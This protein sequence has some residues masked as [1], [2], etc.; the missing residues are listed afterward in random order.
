MLNI[1]IVE[2]EPPI[3]RSLKNMIE[4]LNS[5]Y[6]VLFTARNGRDALC[7]LEDAHKKIDVLFTD[8]RMPVMDGLALMKEVSEK[9][10]SVSLVVLSGYQDFSYVKHALNCK[11]VD[12]LL[13]PISR[14]NLAELM[15]A[16]NTKI[17]QR[18][19]KEL[20][21]QI[22][23]LLEGTAPRNAQLVS[24]YSHYLVALICVGAYPSF[25]ADYRLPGRQLWETTDLSSMLAN[26]LLPNTQAFSFPGKTSAEKIVV[27]FFSDESPMSRQSIT[28][29][30]TWAVSLF[31]ALKETKFP[32]TVVVSDPLSDICQIE[33][34]ANQLRVGLSKKVIIGAS[35]MMTIKEAN[36]SIQA[37]RDFLADK[38]KAIKAALHSNKEDEFKALLQSLFQFF[39]VYKY[40][41]C[42]AEQVLNHL[43]LI[44]CCD[45]SFEKNLPDNLALDIN[46][47]ASNSLSY[48]EFY[49]NV[50]FVF[51]EYFHLPQSTDESIPRKLP[52]KLLADI[53]AYL[54][55]HYTEDITNAT[56][57]RKFNLVPSYLSKLFKTYTGATPSKYLLNLR[58]EHAKHMIEQDPRRLSKDIALN[59]G[60]TDPLYFSRIFKKETGYSPAEY[61]KLCE[62]QRK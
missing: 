46:E 20:E 60:F 44:C 24:G 53:E 57:S 47:A 3:A 42:L 8:I 59:V 1:M 34:I 28:D 12:Y 33:D 54:Q 38:E 62:Q 49:R 30:H 29:M 26:I 10:P 41:Q 37:R 6:S 36:I 23:S 52:S 14:Q 51:E 11:A 32:I 17:S 15:T 9:Y 56:L 19:S 13:K 25:S 43:I 39:E 48:D 31:S 4:S 22:Q 5:D 27:V 58:I 16:L 55:E 40:P 61:K 7:Q 35:Q 50:L 21:Q 45:E 18:K 2:D